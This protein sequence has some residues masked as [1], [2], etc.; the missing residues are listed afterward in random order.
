[1]SARLPK[2]LL[3]LITVLLASL[4]LF[5]AAACGSQSQSNSNTTSQPGQNQVGVSNG[6]E[7]QGSCTGKAAHDCQDPDYS[8]CDK[9]AEVVPNVSPSSK[10]EEMLP[11]TYKN[12]T[13]YGYLGVRQSRPS[14]GCATVWGRVQGITAPAP[15]ARLHIDLKRND[16]AIATF[17]TIDGANTSTRSVVFGNMLSNKRSVGCVTVTAYVDDGP[18]VSTT[19][20]ATNG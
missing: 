19:C 5:A 11:V 10:P 16:G 3:W 14:D 12:G 7:D 15:G 18:P 17:S 20:M 9:T 2:R 1:M 13:V 4:G 8:G 6:Q